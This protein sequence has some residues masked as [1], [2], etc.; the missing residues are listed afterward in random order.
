MTQD[1]YIAVKWYLKAA[2][3]GN[4]NGQYGLGTCYYYGNGKYRDYDKAV[5]LF[6]KAAEQGNANGQYGLGNCYCYGRGVTKDY[7]KALELYKKAANQGNAGA[8]NGLGEC[9]YYGYGVK[10][11]YA[12]AVVWYKKAANQGEANA[13]YSLGYCYK[14][15]EGIARNEQKAIELY[16]KAAAAGNESAS[17]AL[18][19][20]RHEKLVANFKKKYGFD[21]SVNDVR[22]IVKVGRNVLGVIDARN[23]WQS[24]Y[25]NKVNQISVELVKD[26]GASKCYKFYSNWGAFYCGYFWTRNNIITS[27]IP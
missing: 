27:I 1:Y 9:Y 6:R 22:S 13:Q 8:Q 14:K 2:E 23:E 19:D 7:A 24:E 12:T 11:N 5:E 15:G 18:E 17:K 4:A 26:Q 10:K 21:P 3:Q 16:E 20:I 25:G